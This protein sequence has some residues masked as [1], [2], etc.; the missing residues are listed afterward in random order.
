MGDR[1]FFYIYGGDLFLKYPIYGIG[2]TNFP[3]YTGSEL[4][5]HS[6][7]I[8][9]LCE[10]GIIGAVI[11]ILFIL[12]LLIP[13]L[14]M[15]RNNHS[16]A[17]MICMGALMTVLFISFYTWTYSIPRYFLAFG[18]ILSVCRPY[19]ESNDSGFIDG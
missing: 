1:A 2:L 17:F 14:R 3:V 11:Y 13:I 10:C 16:P 6:E 4:P 12:S 7:Y 8:V 19:V 18:I 5:I 9:Q 15:I